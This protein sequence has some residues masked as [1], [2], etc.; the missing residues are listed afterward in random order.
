MVGEGAPV[1][2][3]DRARRG[4]PVA[5]SLSHR[6]LV[7]LDVDRSGALGLEAE[8]DI[9]DVEEAAQQEPGADEQDAGKAD[10]A[11]SELSKIERRE[12]HLLSTL[13]KYVEALGGELEVVAVL[14]DKRIRL[15]GV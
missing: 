11:Q 4:G 10:F 9:E 2:R 3:G 6:G 12:D 5:P 14:G 1:G 8:I 13:R 7:V 15:R